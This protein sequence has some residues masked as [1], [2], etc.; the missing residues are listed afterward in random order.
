MLIGHGALGEA[1]TYPQARPKTFS[2][3]TVTGGRRPR[4][5][6]QIARVR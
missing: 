3:R 4:E 6:A 5:R 1:V 2:E